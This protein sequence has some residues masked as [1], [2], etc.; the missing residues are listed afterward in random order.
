MMRRSRDGEWVAL[1]VAA[2]LDAPRDGRLIEI[3]QLA[4]DRTGAVTVSWGDGRMGIPGSDAEYVGVLPEGATAWQRS[5]NLLRSLVLTEPTGTT[6]FLA[7]ENGRV[8]VAGGH[9]INR[10]VSWTWES[11]LGW[12]ERILGAADA[13][14]VMASAADG[15]AL[16]VERGFGVRNLDAAATPPAPTVRIRRVAVRGGSVIVT[17]QTTRPGR[18]YVAV[19]P[20]TWMN[21]SGGH[22]L[23]GMRR[24]GVHT[25]RVDDLGRGAYLLN[26]GVCEARRGCSVSPARTVGIRTGTARTLA[27][28]PVG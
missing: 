17:L 5:P 21:T 26:T 1:P 15:T 19:R 3:G 10:R 22:V 11:R 6:P 8:L 14:P 18:L 28:R 20:T 25:L 23:T 24:A 2:Q 7:F 16:H 13:Q 9:R 27:A 12:R 4:V